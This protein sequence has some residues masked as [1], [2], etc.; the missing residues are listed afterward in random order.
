MWTP[1]PRHLAVSSL[2]GK[3]SSGDAGKANPMLKAQ[4]QRGLWSLGWFPVRLSL[5]TMVPGGLRGRNVYYSLVS[6]STSTTVGQTLN[7]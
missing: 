4:P 6:A 7:G 5:G 1:H 3:L 2:P